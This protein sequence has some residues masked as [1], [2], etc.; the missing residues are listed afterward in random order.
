VL[1]VKKQS[2]T[3]QDEPEREAGFQYKMSLKEMAC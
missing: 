3:T 2:F 1:E